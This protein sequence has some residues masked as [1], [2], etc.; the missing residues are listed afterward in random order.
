MAEKCTPRIFT[1]N[2]YIYKK[3]KYL[4]QGLTYINSFIEMWWGGGR[5]RGGGSGIEVKLK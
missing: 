5:G 2:K 1:I 3:W 4:Q